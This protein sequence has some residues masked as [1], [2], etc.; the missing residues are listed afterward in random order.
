MRR[1][2]WIGTVCKEYNATLPVRTLRKFAGIL[3]SVG[4]HPTPPFPSFLTDSTFIICLADYVG[5]PYSAVIH[6]H[7]RVLLLVLFLEV[8]QRVPH[9]VS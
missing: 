9:L 8:L 7:I 3:I 6:H 2:K 5:F 4:P 1:E